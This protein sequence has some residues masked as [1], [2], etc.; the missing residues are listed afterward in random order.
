MNIPRFWD[1]VRNKKFAVSVIIFGLLLII[2]GLWNW[3]IRLPLLGTILIISAL[4][5]PEW[6]YFWPNRER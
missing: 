3:D 5:M 4:G 6:G 2:V 1:S